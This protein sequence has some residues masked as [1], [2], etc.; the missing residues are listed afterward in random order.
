M[1][2]GETMRFARAVL[3]RPYKFTIVLLVANVFL[4]LLMLQTSGTPLVFFSLCRMK[5]CCASA[6]N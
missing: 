3:D 1:A 6:R 2:D 4:F 5:C